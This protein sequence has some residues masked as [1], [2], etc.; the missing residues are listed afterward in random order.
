MDASRSAGVS[1]APRVSTFQM[2]CRSHHC[3]LSGQR[4]RRSALR[5]GFAFPASA[6]NPVLRLRLRLNRRG[7]ASPKKQQLST[8]GPERQ[9]LSARQGGRA[10]R[11]KLAKCRNSRRRPVRR[12]GCRAPA[13]SS[14]GVRRVRGFLILRCWCAWTRGVKSSSANMPRPTLS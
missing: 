4:L 13:F 9:S 11:A 8:E 14:A 10:A 12:G 6:L 7:A 2:V 5:K 3:A 1:P